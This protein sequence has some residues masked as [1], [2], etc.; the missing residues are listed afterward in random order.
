MWTNFLPLV[1][2]AW[3]EKISNLLDFVSTHK[4]IDSRWYRS[5]NISVDSSADRWSVSVL[6]EIK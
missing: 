5:K 4:S 3:S 2:I 6:L 1:D